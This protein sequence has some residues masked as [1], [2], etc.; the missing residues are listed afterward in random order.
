[1]QIGCKDN[2]SLMRRELV[3]DAG[4]PLIFCKDT[5]FLQYLQIFSLFINVRFP[6]HG[7][8]WAAVYMPKYILMMLVFTG[9]SL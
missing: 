9:F 7:V 5:P 6:C 8:Q 1:M 2:A 4:A 3:P